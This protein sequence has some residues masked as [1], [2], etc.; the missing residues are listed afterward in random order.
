MLETRLMNWGGDMA[1]LRE[2]FLR[3][4]YR[5]MEGMA[6]QFGGAFEIKDGW[7]DCYAEWHPEDSQLWSELWS[8]T[9]NLPGEDAL[10]LSRGVMMARMGG[11]VLMK[12][13]RY[14]Y[15]IRPDYDNEHC[16]WDKE[17]Y[18]E[19]QEIFKANEIDLLACLRRLV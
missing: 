9:I 4:Y 15:M 12:S 1:T 13:E 18:R 17:S 14:N 16:I 6:K 5:M 3:I 7:I 19:I 10:E 8:M 2:T 11:A